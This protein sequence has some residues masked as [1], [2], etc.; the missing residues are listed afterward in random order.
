MQAGAT[1]VHQS[2]QCTSRHVTED[3]RRDAPRVVHASPRGDVRAVPLLQTKS[4]LPA[5]NPATTL[6]RRAPIR[7]DLHDIRC[8]HV[9][10]E[11]WLG[12]LLG[13]GEARCLTPAEHRTAGH[14]HSDVAG[15]DRDD[16]RRVVCGDG[17][18][19]LLATGADRISGGSHAARLAQATA[20]IGPCAPSPPPASRFSWRRC[21]CHP[22]CVRRGPGVRAGDAPCSWPDCRQ[23]SDV[24]PTARRTTVSAMIPDE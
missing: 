9:A 4:H 5:P 8:P 6:R 10:F 3:L 13:K 1:A 20:S 15:H 7:R 14:C 18:I 17:G 12:H 21:A 23:A 22:A 11:S 2:R 16:R 24:P 19:G